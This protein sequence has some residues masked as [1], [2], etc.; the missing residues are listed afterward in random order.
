MRPA[1]AT[2]SAA[3]A[4]R[5]AGAAVQS[6]HG[7]RTRSL[8]RRLDHLHVRLD[9]APKA[10]A[11]THHSAAPFVDAEAGMFLRDRPLGPGDRALAGLTVAFDA[12]CEER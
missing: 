6:G 11:V 12:S 9:H 10:V 4:A 5:R 2:C 3:P 7:L 8:G 1:S